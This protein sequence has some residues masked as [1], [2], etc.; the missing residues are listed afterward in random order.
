MQLQ[1]IT[2]QEELELALQIRRAVFVDEQGVP[3]EAEIDGFDRLD[4][5][6]EHILVYL[7]GEPAAAGRLRIV[8]GTAKLERICVLSAYRK[9]GL[10]REA[11]RF[12]EKIARERGLIKAK[13][14]SQLQAESF[15]FG[16]GYERA[17]EEFI[18]EGIPHVLMV[19]ALNGNDRSK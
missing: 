10:G 19:K 8:D 5:V 11:V 9:H 18:E 13:L 1:R 7:N 12:L 2:V 4:G 17:S 6:A 3:P 15:Y 14:N 16:L